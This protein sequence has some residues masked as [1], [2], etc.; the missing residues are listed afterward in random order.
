MDLK[1]L[2]QELRTPSLVRRQGQGHLRQVHPG[3]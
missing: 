1:R 3:P 2:A